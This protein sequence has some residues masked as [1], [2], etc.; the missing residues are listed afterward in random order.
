MNYYLYEGRV[1]SS[2]ELMHYG[3]PGMKWGVRKERYKAMNRHERKKTREKYYKTEEGK[4]YKVKRNTII[5]TVLGG[6]V[7]GI[8]SGL[9]TAKR[10]GL[11]QKRVEQ[12]KQYVE[13]LAS[14]RTV[15]LTG[16][17]GNGTR[18]TGEEE[19]Q[20]WKDLAR[21]YEEQQQ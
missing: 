7:V 13:K 1:Y 9:I 14:N 6:P 17:L 15:E 16:S 4:T 8:A 18:V 2:D 11:L 20:F 12:G 5:G 19:A 10:N 21:Y 3:V